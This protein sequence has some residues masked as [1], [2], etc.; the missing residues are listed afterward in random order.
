MRRLP[1]FFARSRAASVRSMETTAASVVQIGSPARR[2]TLSQS[3]AAPNGARF[4]SSARTSLTFTAGWV[5]IFIKLGSSHVSRKT[6]AEIVGSSYLQIFRKDRY[7]TPSVANS[8]LGPA[9][10]LFPCAQRDALSLETPD[11][12]QTLSLA[13][14]QVRNDGTAVRAFWHKPDRRGCDLCGEALELPR[15]PDHLCLGRLQ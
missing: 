13:A 4:S 7:E 8:N 15:V 6:R 9:P 5:A 14:A 1:F 3:S 12:G 2:P 10:D 11:T